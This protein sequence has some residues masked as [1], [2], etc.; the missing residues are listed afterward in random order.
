MSDALNPQNVPS[1]ETLDLSVWVGSE[2][3]IEQH[4]SFYSLAQKQALLDRFTAQDLLVKDDL[5]R[6]ILKIVQTSGITNYQ[7]EKIL[8]ETMQAKDPQTKRYNLSLYL[9]LEIMMSG[10]EESVPLQ[11]QFFD[12]LRRSSFGFLFFFMN[13]NIGYFHEQVLRQRI[14]ELAQMTAE[15]ASD[16]TALYWAHNTAYNVLERLID[17][18]LAKVFDEPFKDAIKR[19]AEQGRFNYKDKELIKSLDRERYSLFADRFK[20]LL[21]LTLLD[22]GLRV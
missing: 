17:P 20:N 9:V 14:K 7:L 16:L 15:S 12:F 2:E 19:Y 1:A 22:L 21:T 6:L 5:L 4:L 10:G 8:Q 11:L 18:A 13:N 3:F